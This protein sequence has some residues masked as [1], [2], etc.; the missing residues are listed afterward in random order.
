M[1]LQSCLKVCFTLLLGVYLLV[2][3]GGANPLDRLVS[4]YVYEDGL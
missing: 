1:Y 2:P 3:Q 4:S